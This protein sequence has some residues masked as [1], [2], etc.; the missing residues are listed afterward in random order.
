[1]RDLFRSGS[2][3]Q[4]ILHGNIFDLVSARIGTT[5]KLLPLKNFLEEAMFSQY[6]V[7][8][9]YDRGKGI[10]CTKGTDDFC[11]WLETLSESDKTMIVRSREPAL[12]LEL[13]DRYLLRTLNLRALNKDAKTAAV[14]AKCPEKIAV[15]IDF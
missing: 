8:L 6:D 9:H 15:I 7:V 5:Q 2:V 1:M 14:A 13:I 12:A 10:R 4:F 11:D 3:S